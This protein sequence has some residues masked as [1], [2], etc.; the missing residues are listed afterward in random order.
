MSTIE[1]AY[2][3]GSG[4]YNIKGFKDFKWLKITSEFGTP[5]DCICVG[6]LNGKK[7]AF[8][9]RHGRNHEINPSN[10]NYRA[11]IDC[12]K[13]LGVQNIIS[14]SAVGSLRIDYI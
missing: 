13:K 2:I 12:L 11:N 6:N 3:G 14:L 4:L 1:I 5:S 9:P 7:I 8:L 10:I